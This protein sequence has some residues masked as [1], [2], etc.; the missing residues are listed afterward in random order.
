M[1]PDPMSKTLMILDEGEPCPACGK[2]EEDGARIDRIDKPREDGKV[3]GH[4]WNASNPT[5]ALWRRHE[6]SK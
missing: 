2:T 1:R 3:D 4:Y 5:R 6:A